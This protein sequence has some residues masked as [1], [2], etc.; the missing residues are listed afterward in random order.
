MKKKDVQVGKV[1]IAKVS[2]TLVPVRLMNENLRRGG[3]DAKNEATGRWI[4]VKTAARLRRE[5]S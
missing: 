1:Y 4:H 5:V 2:N 3:W